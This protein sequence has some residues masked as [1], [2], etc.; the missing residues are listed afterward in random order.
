[1]G[2]NMWQ[3]LL[4]LAIF[5]LLFGRG[6]IPALMGDLAS[7][8]KNFKQGMRED[9]EE[10]PKDTLA[11]RSSTETSAVEPAATAAALSEKTSR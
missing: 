3:I 4:V 2:V 9:E 7:G 8:I 1:M 5:L 10:T 11:N 6:K